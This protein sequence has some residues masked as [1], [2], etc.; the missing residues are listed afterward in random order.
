VTLLSNFFTEPAANQSLL[1]RT[2]GAIL[3]LGFGLLILKFVFA[4]GNFFTSRDKLDRQW[5]QRDAEDRDL[6]L[7]EWK[8]KHKL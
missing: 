7:K 3:I 6:T 4:I 5:Q 2:F 1:G 8:I